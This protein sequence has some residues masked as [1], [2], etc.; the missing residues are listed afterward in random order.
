MRRKRGTRTERRE[1][2]KQGLIDATISCICDVGYFETTT[3]MIARR[4]KVSRGALQYHF[5]SRNDLFQTVAERVGLA[6]F[7]AFDSGVDAATP[8]LARVK[9][10]CDTYWRVFRSKTFAAQVQ[11]WIGAHNDEPLQARIR[12]ITRRMLHSQ[13]RLWQRTF[14]D[15]ALPRERL[16]A[17]RGLTISAVRGLA[18]RPAYRLETRKSPPELDMLSEV[19]AAALLQ[20]KST[21]SA[22]AMR[23]RDTRRRSPSAQRRGVKS[24]P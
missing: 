3:P 10:I 12:S 9:H 22:A 19:I 7:G 4:A 11:I 5:R 16:A 6:L 21:R 1:A 15:L 14:A 20:P 17:L 23:T 8:V 2:T 13:N 24:R 18:L